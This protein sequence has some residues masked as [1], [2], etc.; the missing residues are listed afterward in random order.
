MK[1]I[2][3]LD[4]AGIKI[5]LRV[6]FDRD[7]FD[8]LNEYV[9]QIRDEFSGSANITLYFSMLFQEYKKAD[10]HDLYKRM[11]ELNEEVIRLGLNSESEEP[12][13]RLNYCMADTLDSDVVIA[14]TGKLF[15]CDE[16]EY[17]PQNKSWGTVYDGVTDR[18]LF[19]KLSSPC[20]INEKCLHCCFLPLC[21]PFFAQCCPNRFDNCYEYNLLLSEHYIRRITEG[22]GSSGS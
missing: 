8:G 1:A 2:H 12:E 18:Q 11:L 15:G 20:E 19:E 16:Y 21:T 10:S 5:K 7:N 17:M 3:Y 14:P 22:T 9:R 13:F 6:N 4:E